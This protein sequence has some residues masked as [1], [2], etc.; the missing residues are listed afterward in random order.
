MN[1]WSYWFFGKYSP[2][3]KNEGA[4][5]GPIITAL[6]LF[7]VF[8]FVVYFWVELHGGDFNAPFWAFKLK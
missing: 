5:Y 7:V 8:Y 1:S 6:C 4:R 3:E 2:H